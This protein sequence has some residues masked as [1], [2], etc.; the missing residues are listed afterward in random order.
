MANENNTNVDENQ[1]YDAEF[2]R[3]ME[4]IAARDPQ[5]RTAEEDCM[6]ASWYFMQSEGKD[7]ELLQNAVDLLMRHAITLY[8]SP[9]WNYHVGMC[10]YYLRQPE[11]AM[12]YLEK[13]SA[14]PEYT[15]PCTQ[16]LNSCRE[17]LQVPVFAHNFAERCQECYRNLLEEVP[18]LLTDIR[19]Q[20]ESPEGISSELN[21]RVRKLL[22][23][24]F[25]RVSFSISCEKEPG[26]L[27]LDPVITIKPV[28]S[29]ARAL[30]IRYFIE[31]APGELTQLIRLRL[32]QQRDE[33]L[34]IPLN[35]GK[36]SAGLEDVSCYI[37]RRN[38]DYNVYLYC[39][40]LKDQLEANVYSAYSL[41]LSLA[42]AALGE[43]ASLTQHVTFD[44]IY[45]DK[46]PDDA[47]GEA[48]ALTDLYQWLVN[49]GV[50]LDQSEDDLFT[51]SYRDYDF[52]VAPPS[53]AAGGCSASAT[54]DRNVAPATAAAAHEDSP[55]S[56]A[57]AS[58]GSGDAVPAVN[59]LADRTD[60]KTGSSRTFQLIN[61]FSGNSYKMT[62]ELHQNGSVAG[63]LAVE[64]AS[65]FGI[66]A[67]VSFDDLIGQIHDA[68]NGS[69]DAQLGVVTGQAVGSH[70]YY[71]D[72]ISW[73]LLSI[74]SNALA[75]F[76]KYGIKPSFGT[77]RRSVPTV[78]L[79][80]RQE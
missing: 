64:A 59:V 32:G 57:A 5:S 52:S 44:V 22:N 11:S 2:V 36:D 80:D 74:L 78:F 51:S 27:V 10:Y 48:V 1:E 15:E 14:D 63:Y 19:Q 73:D 25:A 77:F 79:S 67:K 9:I 72:F 39:S 43:L 24:A 28:G 8:E 26:A 40:K 30:Q 47:Q 13:A 45:D 12:R 6:L 20:F 55:E 34:R 46:A 54:A 17:T 35:E 41:Y 21:D 70:F 53:G 65:V 37:A 29:I 7:Q 38:N 31:H 16:Y 76:S 4:V 68:I 33:S 3:N 49:A 50:R 56:A 66:N 61:E 60:I 71:I 58:S 42:Y 23:F 62:D 18:R 69:Q 75:V